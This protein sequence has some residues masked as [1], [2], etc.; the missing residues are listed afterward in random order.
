[1]PGNWNEFD[2][3]TLL[4]DLFLGMQSAAHRIEQHYTVLPS[5]PQLS[6]VQSEMTRSASSKADVMSYILE[7][8][9][10]CTDSLSL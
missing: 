6:S 7:M 8:R 4:L 9:P 3:H 1:M 5:F 2:G 10:T